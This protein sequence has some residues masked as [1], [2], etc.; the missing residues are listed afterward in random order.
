MRFHFEQH[1]EACSITPAL[2]VQ[3][4]E[5]ECCDNS[6]GICFSLTWL[7]WSAGIIFGGGE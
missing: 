4:M 6:Q 5:C 2:V 1:Y 7:F 3:S